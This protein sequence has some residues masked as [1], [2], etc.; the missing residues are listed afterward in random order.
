MYLGIT[1]LPGVLISGMFRS[2][3]RTLFFQ[4]FIQIT[5][6]YIIDMYE[7]VC[8]NCSVF[9]LIGRQDVEVLTVGVGNHVIFSSMLE[10][11]L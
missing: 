10:T 5:G 3:H 2:R 9:S 4:L 7:F 11:L 8:N 1:P 6:F